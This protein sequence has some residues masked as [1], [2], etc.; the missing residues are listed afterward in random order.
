SYA[1]LPFQHTATHPTSTLPL[2]DAPPISP[3]RFRKDAASYTSF[4]LSSLKNAVSAPEK[5]FKKP[6]KA[7][8]SNIF[9][10]GMKLEAVDV[11]HPRSEE[12]TSELQSRFEIV[13]RLLLENNTRE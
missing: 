5:A 2:H 12:H 6:P 9:E 7:P 4:C 11:K 13:C 3:L 8:S 10:V 1:Q